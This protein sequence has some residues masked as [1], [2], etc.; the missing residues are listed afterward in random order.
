MIIS[1]FLKMFSFNFF[2]YSFNSTVTNTNILKKFAQSVSDFFIFFWQ[3]SWFLFLFQI[4][5]FRSWKAN[6]RTR[7]RAKRSY[8][9]R[10]WVERKRNDVSASRPNY[11]KSSNYTVMKNMRSILFFL[12]IFFYSDTLTN[13]SSIKLIIQVISMIDLDLDFLLLNQFISFRF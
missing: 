12:L 13:H 9:M 4:K 10:R 7:R 1:L 6:S 5:K 11:V 2:Y 3:D 8:R